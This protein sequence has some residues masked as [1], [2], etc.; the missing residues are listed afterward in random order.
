MYVHLLTCHAFLCQL[1]GIVHWYVVKL[2]VSC[3]VLVWNTT[4]S[5]KVKNKKKFMS[6]RLSLSAAGLVWFGWPRI[7]SSSCALPRANTGMRQRPPR[8][9][10]SWTV[11]GEVKKFGIKVN[12]III[13]VTQVAPSIKINN[14]PCLT[15]KWT[16]TL[17]LHAFHECVFQTLIPK[18]LI[19]DKRDFPYHIPHSNTEIYHITDPSNYKLIANRQF[20]TH[21]D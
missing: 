13:I 18:K 4:W 10:M 16:L 11:A 14:R 19:K 2:R 5:I 20:W 12:P 17:S 7:S 8:V 9:T 1:W 21:G 6:K 3:P 15:Y